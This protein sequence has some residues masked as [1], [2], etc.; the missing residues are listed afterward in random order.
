ERYCFHREGSLSACRKAGEDSTP[1]AGKPLPGKCVLKRN[2]SR[3]GIVFR[4]ERYCFEGPKHPRL[5][6]GEPRV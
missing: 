2:F 5:I 6:A 3:L 4:E 1:A